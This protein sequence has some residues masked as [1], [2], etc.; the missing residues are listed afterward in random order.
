M[1]TEQKIDKIYEVC[2]RIDPQVQEH[3]IT[4]YG[5]DKPGLKEDVTLLQ[6]RQENCPARKATTAEGKRLNIAVWALVIAILT[7]IGTLV[8][9]CI[10]LLNSK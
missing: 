8:I 4:L 3:H 5:N 10:S 2:C 1:N 6:E 7:G 9:G